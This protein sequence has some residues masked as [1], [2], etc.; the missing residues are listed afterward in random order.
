MR[1]RVLLALSL[2]LNA[3]LA[4][5]YFNASKEVASAP[6]EAPV[7]VAT[8][9][10]V[11]KTN[12]VVRRQFFHWSQIE[13][14]DYAVFIENLRSIG[15]PEV[16][17]RDII[18]ADVNEMFARRR[19]TEVVTGE[20]EWWRSEPSMD[21]TQ[22]AMEKGAALEAERVALLTKLLGPNWDVSISQPNER[23]TVSLDGPVLGVMPADTKLRVQQLTLDARRRAAEYVEAQRAAGKEIDPVELAKFR[24]DHR[25]ELSRILTPEQM[26]EY[27]LRHSANA[28]NLRSALKGFEATP[29]EFRSI[30]RARDSI[31]NE[32]ALNFSGDD[33]ASVRRRQELE[34][35]RDAAVEQALGPDRSVVYRTIQDPLFREAQFLAEQSGAPPE[36]VIPLYRVQQ[37][38]ARERA[39]INRD[40]SMTAEER[41]TAIRQV[42]ELEEAARQQILGISPPVPQ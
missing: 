14:D 2:L 42:E 11:G 6:D 27:L 37:E 9:N 38:G 39:R 28:E 29:D 20:S 35:M 15:C 4:F 23:G 7:V 31:D 26:E 41:A 5:F 36:R 8:T 24:R 30:F 25:A 21:T 19:A 18:V 33:A 34:R 32:I 12:V 40:T 10:R 13:S 3:A 1:L 22:A 16:T 17:I